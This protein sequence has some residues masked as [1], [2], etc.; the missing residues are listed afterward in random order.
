MC[1][2]VDVS[3]TCSC[4]YDVVIYVCHVFSGLTVCD[5]HEVTEIVCREVSGVCDTLGV[6]LNTD[7]WSGV[8]VDCKGHG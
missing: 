6:S 5:S 2:I 1:G 3:V 7:V 8:D 4:Y